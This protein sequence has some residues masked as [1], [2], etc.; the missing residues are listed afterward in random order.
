[1]NEAGDAGPK[2]AP[3]WTRSATPPVEHVEPIPAA[4]PAQ[5][6]R[7]ELLTRVLPLTLAA[8]AGVAWALAGAAPVVAVAPLWSAY[9]FLFAL[10]GVGLLLGAAL[11]ARPALVAIPVLAVL[12]NYVGILGGL[13]GLSSESDPSRSGIGRYRSWNGTSRCRGRLDLQVEQR[14]IRIRRDFASHETTVDEID[15][16]GDSIPR[17]TL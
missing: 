14:M 8:W 1:M 3:R 6:T 10:A 17:L 7:R 4:E 16:S 15:R 2:P 9:Y 12:A 11:A 5:S 13:F